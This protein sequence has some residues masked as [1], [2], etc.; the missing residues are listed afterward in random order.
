MLKQT[1]GFSGMITFRI[2]GGLKEAKI[3]LEATKIFMLAE[4]LG[5]VES[6]CEHP[7]ALNGCS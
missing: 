4:S 3:F 5:A 7:F 2:K 6:L 1:G